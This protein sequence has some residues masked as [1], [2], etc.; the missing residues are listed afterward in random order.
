[1]VAPSD[2]HCLTAR[3]FVVLLLRTANTWTEHWSYGSETASNCSYGTYN[4]NND[5]SDTS[6]STSATS[7]LRGD[8][9]RSAPMLRRAHGHT[10][11]NGDYYDDNDTNDNDNHDYHDC[12]KYYSGTMANVHTHYDQDDDHNDHRSHPSVLHAGSAC[13]GAF[14]VLFSRRPRTS[15]IAML[16]VSGARNAAASILSAVRVVW[17]SACATSHYMGAAN[18]AV[19]Y[20]VA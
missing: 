5:N 10:H 7:L 8:H 4:S 6:T 15:A 12:Y 19:K 14:A 20:K 17:V 16:F 9:T 1:M 3:R 18:E 13:A 2:S 11:C